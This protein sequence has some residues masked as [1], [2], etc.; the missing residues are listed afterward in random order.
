MYSSPAIQANPNQLYLADFEY[1][2]AFNFISNH[3][4]SHHYF[5]YFP[6]VIALIFF[7]YQITS[8]VEWQYFL[9]V[10]SLFWHVSLDLRNLPCSS[11]IQ[12]KP[13]NWIR[14]NQ[15]YAW[16]SLLLAR[17]F[18]RLV[19]H[20]K[21]TIICYLSTR[22]LQSKSRWRLLGWINCLGL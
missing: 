21:E 14:S 13:Y 4:F 6:K 3:W 16:F 19:S 1:G 20:L 11:Q 12:R 2:L 15:V 5:L 7:P 17:I 10:R 8:A 18:Y 9:V 22:V